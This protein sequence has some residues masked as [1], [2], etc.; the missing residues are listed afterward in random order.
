MTQRNQPCPCNSGLKY[1][2][3]CGNPVETARNVLKK[4]QEAQIRFYEEARKRI[5]Q[6]EDYKNGHLTLQRPMMNL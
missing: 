1:K 5:K 2:R 4:R 3:C 6:L